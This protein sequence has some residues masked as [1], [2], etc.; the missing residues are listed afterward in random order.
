MIKRKF[1][2][3][4]ASP[5]AILRDEKKAGTPLGIECEKLTSRGQLLPDELVVGLVKSWLG[6]H[7]GAFTFDGFPRTRGQ[8]DTL[9]TLLAERNTPLDVAFSLDA[10]FDTIRDRVLRRMVCD[11]CG[12]IVSV[13]LHV[14]APDSPCPDCGGKLHRRN[15]DNEEILHQRM[16]EYRSKSEPL[17]SYYTGHCLLRHIDANRTPEEVFAGIE[18]ILEK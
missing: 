12:N 2:I 15:D 18:T 16:D 7:N 5:G 1:Q 14:V 13:G 3:P 9:E 17:I 8:A 11:E 6:E 4:A 10:D